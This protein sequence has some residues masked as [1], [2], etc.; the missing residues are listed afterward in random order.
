MSDATAAQHTSE[1]H[2][3]L[4]FISTYVFSTDHKMIGKQFLMLGLLMFVVGWGL[5]RILPR[6]ARDLRGLS[7]WSR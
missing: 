4:G 7:L 2:A 5:A 6:A 1:A 3:P